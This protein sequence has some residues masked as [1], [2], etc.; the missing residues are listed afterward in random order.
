MSEVS[1][2]SSLERYD[3]LEL[4]GHGGMGSVH[5][6][7]D[8]TDGRCLALKRLNTRNKRSAAGLTEMFHQEFRALAQLRHPHVVEVYDFGI[9]AAGPYYTMEWLDG[10]DL[11]GI[12]PLSWREVCELGRDVCSAL[13]LL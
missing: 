2:Q 13:A 5:R 12:A 11:Q 4:L 3:V 10:G 6:V 7:I 1:M 8:R 9:D